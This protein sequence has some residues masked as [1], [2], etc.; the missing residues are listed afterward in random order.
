MIEVRGKDAIVVVGSLKLTVP[1][2]SL[3]E[4]REQPQRDRGQSTSGDAPEVHVSTEI[5]LL[6]L[7]AD[8]AESAVLQALD[9]AV[10]ADLKSLRIIHGKGTGALR[11]VVD[12][13]L[14]KDTRVR[15]FR[16]GRV[17]RGRRGRHHRG[18]R[19]IPDETVERV[20]ESADIVGVI[21]EYVELKRQGT[22]YRG[23]CPFHQ[24]TH[25][26]FSVSPKK[27]MYHCFVC[28][29]GGDV[30]K[31]LTKRLGVDLPTAVK[32]VGE[33]SGI[34]VVETQSRRAEQKDDAR[35]ALGGERRRGR[36]LPP[37]ALGGRSRP[38]RARVSRRARAS[39]AS[40]PTESGSASRRARS[41]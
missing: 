7:R 4:H 2:T 35:A 32:M 31:F 12:E 37:H 11:E 38:R 20:R 23:P 29:E 17:E 22:D 24:G 15:E 3:R 41:A 30:F 39:R 1:R 19:V 5:D 27:A 36:L 10:R 26:N 6:G 14:R 25:R 8:E 16:H 18:V 9:S 13:M 28:D 33:K 34:E 40:S 21:G